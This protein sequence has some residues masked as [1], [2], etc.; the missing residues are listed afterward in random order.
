VVEDGE[1]AQRL[2]L[3][4]E[5]D[6]LI[7]DMGLPSQEGYHILQALR[8][9]G[10]TLP[11]IVLTGRRDRGA[12]LCLEGG[13]DDYLT[14]PFDFDELV[15]RIRARL[16]EVGTDEPEALSRG[17]VRLELKT[18]RASVG[19]RTAD[20]TTREFSLLETFLRHPNQILTREQ[21]ASQVWGYYVDPNTNLVS[22]YIGALR[23]KLGADVIETVR[24]EGYRLRKP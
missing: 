10:K 11:V 9:R 3:S 24:G 4:D 2:G 8:A 19:D 5:F 7:L 12:A 22:V 15:A 17:G 16:R 23:R 6:L 1:V 13:A 21:I 20:L 14:K 18:R